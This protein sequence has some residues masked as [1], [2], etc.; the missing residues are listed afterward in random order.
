MPTRVK[1]GKGRGVG[2]DAHIAHQARS[3]PAGVEL[4]VLFGGEADRRRLVEVGI[5]ADPERARSC[6][7]RSPMV[8]WMTPRTLAR[9][10]SSSGGIAAKFSASIIEAS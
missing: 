2:G 8:A 10:A 5:E 3:Q 9:R 1:L 6:A 7:G 4:Q